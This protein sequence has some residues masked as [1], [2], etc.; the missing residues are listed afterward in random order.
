M[1]KI[2]F[3]LIFVSGISGCKEED[4]LS[5]EYY[6]NSEHER[7]TML[8]KCRTLPETNQNCINARKARF[9]IESENA[10][11]LAQDLYGVSE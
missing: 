8:E 6:K 2:V 9:L 4:I 5:V 11:D 7:V 3:V 10:S 1:K